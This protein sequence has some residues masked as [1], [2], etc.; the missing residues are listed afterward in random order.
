MSRAR[1]SLGCADAHAHRSGG[2][3]VISP[4]A[5]TALTISYDD[6]RESSNAADAT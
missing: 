5:A 4:Q 1:C 6:L 3:T 2:L